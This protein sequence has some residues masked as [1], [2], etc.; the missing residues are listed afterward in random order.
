MNRITLVVLMMVLSLSQAKAQF[1]SAPG[2]D[3][4]WDTKAY[5]K[6]QIHLSVG[7]GQPRLENGLFKYQQDSTDFRVV[8]IGPF[9]SR[10]EYGLTR[11]LSVAVSA[12]WIRYKSEWKQQRPDPLYGFDLPFR[13]GTEAND[14]FANLRLNYHLFVSKDWDVYIGGGLGYN[15]FN[16]KDFTSYGPD[17]TTFKSQFKI[18]YPVSYE[19]TFGARYFF[20][21]RTAI[22]LEVGMGKSVVQG[23]FVFKFRHRKRG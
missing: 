14:I 1:F 23:G 17:S 22:Y 7:Y 20:L 11:K 8:G 21:T 18:P 19:M 2:W 4:Y 16:N 13:Y 9:Y 6:G 10:L 15:T 5:E 12:G 3:Y